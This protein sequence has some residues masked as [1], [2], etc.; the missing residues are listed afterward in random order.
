MTLWGSQDGEGRRP[1]VRELAILA[2]LAL[3]M[4]DRELCA[5]IVQKLYDCYDLDIDSQWRTPDDD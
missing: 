2:D 5:E 3:E 1:S 4:G